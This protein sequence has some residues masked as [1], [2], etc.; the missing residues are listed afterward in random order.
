MVERIRSVRR[1]LELD[2]YEIEDWFALRETKMPP[3]PTFPAVGFIMEG[4]AAGFIYLTDSTV[5]IIDCYISNPKSNMDLRN[6]ALDLITEELIKVARFH[7]CRLVKCDTK[8]EAV[9]QRAKKHGLISLGEF[10]S[11]AM[12]I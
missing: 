6:Y 9:K 4:V 7:K 3:I 11:F 2:F 5:A 1:V 12:E 10:E 8:L